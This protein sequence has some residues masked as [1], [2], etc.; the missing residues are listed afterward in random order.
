MVFKKLFC[1][2][3]FIKYSKVFPELQQYLST[4]EEKHLMIDTEFQELAILKLS[5][6]C[7]WMPSLRVIQYKEENTLLVDNWNISNATVNRSRKKTTVTTAQNYFTPCSPLN[8][9]KN[10][11]IIASKPQRLIK[12]SKSICVITYF[13]IPYSFKGDYKHRWCFS[14][15]WYKED[16]RPHLKIMLIAVQKRYLHKEATELSV[17]H[18]GYWTFSLCFILQCIL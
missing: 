4:K 1:Y 13:K 2:F 8:N 9:L 6:T 17:D 3:C 5:G 16:L 7:T 14:M 11:T 10:K 15:T 18:Y 12:V